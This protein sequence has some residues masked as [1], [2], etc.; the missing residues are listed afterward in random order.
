MRASLR[1]GGFNTLRTKGVTPYGCEI[2]A[3]IYRY[4]II[5]GK[6]I[7]TGFEYS[8]GRGTALERKYDTK[9][10]VINYW[11]NGTDLSKTFTD[12]VGEL[13]KHYSIAYSTAHGWLSKCGI[14]A[15]KKNP[16]VCPLSKEEL[17]TLFSKHEGSI[18]AVRRE[19]KISSWNQVKKWLD[20]ANIKQVQTS[21]TKES[22]CDPGANVEKQEPAL[23]SISNNMNE[24]IA[25]EPFPGEELAPGLN[26][27]KKPEQ[28]PPYSK[29]DSIQ[30]KIEAYNMMDEFYINAKILVEELIQND[31]ALSMIK[32]L[33][34][35]GVV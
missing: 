25:I 21:P 32:N 16:T 4:K 1:L 7:F 28:L 19:L 31:M 15:D 6:E 23:N 3:T 8:G 20:E 2:D 27:N 18:N 10:D 26:E 5:N 33:I 11:H 14:K 30:S 13:A 35:K 9:E 17:Q 34:R 22:D 24:D 29:K 12:R